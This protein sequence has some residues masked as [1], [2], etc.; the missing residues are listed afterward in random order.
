VRNKVLDAP[1]LFRAYQRASVSPLF[2]VED[3]EVLER[4][5]NM[6]PALQSVAVRATGRDLAAQV[7]RIIANAWA[8]QLTSETERGGAPPPEREWRVHDDVNMF[9]EAGEWEG[10]QASLDEDDDDDDDD[11]SE[12]DD[13]ELMSRSLAE[14]RA[15]RVAF[16]AAMSRLVSTVES[17]GVPA[18]LSELKGCSSIEDVGSAFRGALFAFFSLVRLTLLESM[19]KRRNRDKAKGIIDQTPST[20][21]AL[22]F[23]V[24]NPIRLAHLGA[25][26]SVTFGIP[27]T[28]RTMLQQVFRTLTAIEK[29]ETRLAKA[30]ALVDDHTVAQLSEHARQCFSLGTEPLSDWPTSLSDQEQ[31][32]FRRIVALE[33][34][35]LEKQA[36]VDFGASEEMRFAL[37]CFFPILGK[38]ILQQWKN[39]SAFAVSAWVDALRMLIVAVESGNSC[40]IAAVISR[41][42]G[43]LFQGIKDFLC[44]NEDVVHLLFQWLFS[45]YR[46][47][48]EVIDLEK[49]VAQNEEAIL[50]EAKSLHEHLAR[51]GKSALLPTP[52]ID[53]LC[54]EFREMLR[55]HLRHRSLQHSLS[56]PALARA[57]KPQMSRLR[58]VFSFSK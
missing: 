2:A 5:M 24:A 25:K 49:L 32:V 48:P 9:F 8:A 34:R 14:R 58:R 43:M 37:T 56:V 36:L 44:G 54:S 33:V 27:F 45:V 20:L 47:G 23:R 40:E 41:I 7:Y 55:E 26:L 38:P 29:T 18:F 4:F 52:H 42:E 30:C 28:G 1:V 3:L 53:E 6:L 11:L 22:L 17:I 12:E 46:G 39:N 57:P 21:M 16:G 35:R 10:T 31:L 19:S 13:M 50:Q 15:R 51:G